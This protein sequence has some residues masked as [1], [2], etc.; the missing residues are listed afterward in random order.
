MR[1]FKTKTVSLFAAL[2]TVLN[3]I[4]TAQA[5]PVTEL[6]GIAP[7]GNPNFTFDDTMTSDYSNT[8]QSWYDNLFYIEYNGSGYTLFVAQQGDFTYSPSPSETLQ[9]TDGI[10]NLY[11][12]FDSSGNFLDGMMAIAGR[13]PGVG[14]NDSSTILTRGTL[15]SYEVSGSVMGFSADITYCDAAIAADCNFASPESVYFY[16]AENL[17]DIGSLGGGNYQSI[18]ASITTVPIPASMW[19]M[20]SALSL[21]AMWARRKTVAA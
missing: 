17:P 13:V 8:I 20:F 15:N 19:L 14:I 7:S 11:A 3:L 21:C 6:P 9:G 12:N 2:I 18:L 10:F 1:L 16:T 4:G 5:L